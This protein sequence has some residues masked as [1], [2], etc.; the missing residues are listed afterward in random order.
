[1]IICFTNG[2]IRY[3]NHL[4]FCLPALK[5]LRYFLIDSPEPS[6]EN[7]SPYP[8][9]NSIREIVD[10]AWNGPSLNIL[11]SGECPNLTT[12]KTFFKSKYTNLFKNIPSL[13]TL[14]LTGLKAD[15][16]TLETIHDSLPNLESFK[17]YRCKFSDSVFHQENIK[18]AMPITTCEYDLAKIRPNTIETRLQL[19][20]YMRRK[21][22]NLTAFTFRGKKITT[23]ADMKELNDPGWKPLLA[24]WKSRLNKIAVGQVSSN[25]DLLAMMGQAD[26]RVKELLLTCRSHD[27][28]ANIEHSLQVGYIQT[29]ELSLKSESTVGDFGWLKRM[30]M[31]G[32][33]LMN[34]FK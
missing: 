18:S 11:S 14:D 29:L 6:P 15:F 4:L 9:K 2:S 34:H 24:S 27:V 26:C 13:T 30:S 19:L 33:M 31:Y 32:L 12:L 16:N 8:W 20:K 23:G 3:A 22:L 21:Y 1:V 28:L 5:E 17:I 25:I 7:A 10:F